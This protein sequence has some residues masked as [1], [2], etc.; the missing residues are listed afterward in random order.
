MKKPPSAILR[1][2]GEYRYL[3]NFWLAPVFWEGVLWPSTEHAY[4]AA[5]CEDRTLWKYFVEM[6]PGQ[7]KR[8]GRGKFDVKIDEETTLS[9]EFDLRKDWEEVKVS[10]M[11][12]LVLAKFTQNEE[13]GQMLLATGNAHLEEGNTWGDKIWGVCPPGSGTGRNELG[14]ILMLVRAQLR[15]EIE[16]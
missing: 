13:L 15:G 3:S 8:A 5:K 4:Q 12:E 6:T 9:F 11:H 1:F 14:K 7:V 16:L 2:F 10:I